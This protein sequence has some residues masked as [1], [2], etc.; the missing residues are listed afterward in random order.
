MSRQGRPQRA[1]SPGHD[2]FAIREPE[3]RCIQ[4]RPKE[5]LARISVSELRQTTISIRQAL[6]SGLSRAPESEREIVRRLYTP[7]HQ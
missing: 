6:E 2:S 1:N 4:L 5:T 3:S 7:A